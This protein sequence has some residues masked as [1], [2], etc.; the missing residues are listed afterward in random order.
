[1]SFDRAVLALLGAFVLLAGLACLAAPA[2][3]AQ[4][5][6]WSATPAGLTEIRA[7]YGGL[8][9]GFGCFLIWC[10]REHTRTFFGLL[11]EG[12]VVG[13]VGMARGLGMLIDR[14]PTMYLLGNLAVEAAT[15]A[16]VAVAISWHRRHTRRNPVPA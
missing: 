5:A 4:Q 12:L 16:L 15:V 6:G 11:V 7:F 14:S 3:L 13:G 1:M 2:S 10:S 8:Q 9:I